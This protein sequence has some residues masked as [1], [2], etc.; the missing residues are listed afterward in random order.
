MARW[1]YNTAS[2]RYHDLDSGKFL[3]TKSVI[4]IRDEIVTQA[5]TDARALGEKVA[6]GEISRAAFG[7]E[8]RKLIK[9]ANTANYALGRGGVNAMTAQDRGALGSLLRGEYKALDGFLRDVQRKTV[10]GDAVAN[11]AELFIDASVGA[12]ERG[13]MAAQGVTMDEHPPLHPRC[14]CW[15]SYTTNAA[16]ETLVTWH[17]GDR[18][19]PECSALSERY[20]GVV[21]ST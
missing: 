9:V 4:R 11:R 18:P 5:A 6:S 10:E 2:N 21:V 1:G 13:K 14:A 20:Q 19:C 16:G 12:H 15:L 7:D 17:L 8:M 3:S